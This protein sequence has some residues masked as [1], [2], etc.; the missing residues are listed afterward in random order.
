MK[1]RSI[2]K[3]VMLPDIEKASLWSNIEEA[4]V[5]GGPVSRI[6]GGEHV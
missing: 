2:D 6:E 3:L 5:S 1:E 4:K